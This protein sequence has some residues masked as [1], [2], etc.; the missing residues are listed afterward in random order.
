MRSKCTVMQS[1]AAWSRVFR[2]TCF[3]L[4]LGWAPV[5][6]G[7]VLTVD[8]STGQSF[9]TTSSFIDESVNV[10]NFGSA[11]GIVDATLGVL[12][13]TDASVPA[14]DQNGN[15]SGGVLQVSAF[16]ADDYTFHSSNPGSN[17]IAVHFT[18]DGT[19]VI[20]ALDVQRD[21]NFGILTLAPGNGGTGT[22]SIGLTSDP[23]SVDATTTLVQPGSY[24]VSEIS[25]F[26]VTFQGSQPL[27][28]IFEMSLQ[29]I[30]GV[31][32][33]FSSTAHISFDLPPGT[34]VTSAGGFVQTASVPE[35][36]SIVLILAGLA[37]IAP[38]IR[39]C[40]WALPRSRS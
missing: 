4:V 32:L 15:P 36:S 5:E 13:A 2:F 35:P 20:P 9:Q 39:L 12:K 16:L 1:R 28:L 3:G 19:M 17:T 10:A 22:T 18:A 38:G 11:R 6:A 37:T 27:H 7:T 8:F 34:S 14:R 25:T 33:D 21:A 23:S 24:P 31:S 40:R 30:G 26:D 29:A